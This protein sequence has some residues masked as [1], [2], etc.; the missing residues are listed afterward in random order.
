M[1]FHKT[2]ASGES[3]ASESNFAS[4]SQSL[5]GRPKSSQ[6]V[7]DRIRLSEIVP[8]HKRP[9]EGPARAE[10]NVPRAQGQSLQAQKAPYPLFNSTS[11]PLIHIC[12][13]FVDNLNNRE[14]LGS[15]WCSNRSVRSKSQSSQVVPGRPTSSNVVP[16]GPRSYLLVPVPPR[17]SHTYNCDLHK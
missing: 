17:L 11:D 15:C 8:R 12:F 1:Q 13:S 10:G 4:S 14:L 7:T 6:V 2:A 16:G 5:P 9:R 3:L